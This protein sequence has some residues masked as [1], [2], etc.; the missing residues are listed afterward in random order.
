MLISGNKYNTC[1]Y[2][3]QRT[4]LILPAVQCQLLASLLCPLPE[5]NPSTIIKMKISNWLVFK[6]NISSIS[7]I[8]WSLIQP[9]VARP[10]GVMMIWAFRNTLISYSE[11]QISCVFAFFTLWKR[12]KT[13]VL[14]DQSVH[15][16]HEYC[17]V[18]K[19]SKFGAY[20]YSR[21]H[22][23]TFL[24]LPFILFEGE[25]VYIRGVQNAC[26]SK[27]WCQKRSDWMFTINHPIAVNITNKCGLRNK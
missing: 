25:S 21:V 8:S 11:L 18:S 4:W 13:H 2:H 17:Y 15:I 6:S 20:L 24:L 9:P 27:H 12:V 22:N 23:N 5:C 1:T 26:L 3:L 16:T 14:S 19:L 7:D 10:Y